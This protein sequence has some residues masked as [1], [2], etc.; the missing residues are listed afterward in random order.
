MAYAVVDPQITLFG[1]TRLRALVACDAC[2]QARRRCGGGTS[3][4]ECARRGL[5][6]VYS[7]STKKRGPRFTKTA[8][9]VDVGVCPREIHGC[10][11]VQLRPSSV[12]T[13]EEEALIISPCAIGYPLGVPGA[14]PS[15][16][17]PLLSQSDMCSLR[18]VFCFTNRMVKVG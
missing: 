5:A 8:V 14:A 10:D 16:E 3:C 1:A 6:C 11:S 2:K 17:V 12:A 7:A 18:R 4:C 15:M 13:I 9:S